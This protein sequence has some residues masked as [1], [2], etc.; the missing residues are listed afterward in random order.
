MKKVLLSFALAAI[1]GVGASAADP[2][3]KAEC[4]TIERISMFAPQLNDTIDIDVWL[5]ENFDRE[6][7]YP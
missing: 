7:R 2:I 5:P 3:Q 4:G 1:C 6:K